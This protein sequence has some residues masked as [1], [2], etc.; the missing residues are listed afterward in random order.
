MKKLWGKIQQILN[1]LKK[2]IWRIRRADLSPG[3]FL[4][5]KILR[6]FL[7]SIR[8]YNNDEYQ[9]RSSA[10]TFYSLIS[11]VPVVAVAFGIAKGFGFEKVLETQFRTKLAGQGEIVSK[12]IKISHSLLENTREGLI[13]AIALIIL[14]WAVV[15]LLR[16][17]EGS[18]NDIW[19]VKEKRTI[20]RMFSDYLSLMILCP[21]IFLLSSGVN[22]FISTQVNMILEKFAILGSLSPIIF[23]LLKLLPYTLLWILFTFLYIFIPNTK[24]HFSS[25]LF[26]GILIGTIFQIVEK[27]YIFLQI[28]VVKYNAIYGGFAI[29]PLFL[30]WLQLSWLIVL[31]GA[32]LSFAS[33]H[34]DTYEFEPDVLQNSHR[35]RNILSLLIIRLL[36][37]NFMKGRKPIT[38]TEMSNQMEIPFHLIKEIISDLVESN[39]VS[40]VQTGKT[41]ER[42]YQPAIDVNIITLQYV[43]DALEKREIDKVHF[44]NNPEFAALSDAL[45]TFGRSIQDLPE[46][47]LLKE[48]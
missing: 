2:D 32:E 38:A 1:F 34:P 42:G 15:N 22:V 40:V 12:I 20:S 37:K 24:V 31:F 26:A 9:L 8:R 46:N 36:I 17:I 41:K 33:Q 6:T 11:I 4:F 30:A 13:A 23:F 44:P 43:M 27:T 47:K 25:G 35:F 19:K 3:K 29:L 48:I 21:L 14:L 45:E 28:A 7:I 10:L 16:Q 39:L 5:V 18:F